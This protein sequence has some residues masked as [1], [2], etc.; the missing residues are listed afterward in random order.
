[1]L[2]VCSATLASGRY[3]AFSCV[4]VVV[5]PSQILL[6]GLLDDLSRLHPCHWA[7]LLRFVVVHPRQLFAMGL[8]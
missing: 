8:L 5:H 4:F 3:W 6:L 1:M 7:Y 2:Q